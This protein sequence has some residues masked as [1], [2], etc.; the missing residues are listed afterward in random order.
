MVII[1][2]FIILNAI[3]GLT[4]TFYSPEYHN[5]ISKERI[6]I[7]KA[8]EIAKSKVFIKNSNRLDINDKLLDN[9]ITKN[10]KVKTKVIKRGNI[11]ETRANW[12]KYVR[13]DY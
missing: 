4:V 11:N 8:T 6:I 12:V 7:D 9:L 2:D 5:S 3:V 13:K 10:I 1:C